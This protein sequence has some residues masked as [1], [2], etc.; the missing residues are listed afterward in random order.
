MLTRLTGVALM[1]S[2]LM[3]TVWSRWAGRLNSE[4]PISRNA[5]LPAGGVAGISLAVGAFALLGTGSVALVSVQVF[6]VASFRQPV[7]LTISTFGGRLACPG[8]C[9]SA[10][11]RSKNQGRHGAV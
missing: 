10:R 7:T 3:M 2:P 9:D 8:P 6:G 4:T 1:N 5:F 11:A